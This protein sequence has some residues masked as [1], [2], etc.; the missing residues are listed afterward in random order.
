MTT[1]LISVLQLMTIEKRRQ[2][3]YIFN[4]LT[5][6]ICHSGIVHLVGVSIK[7]EVKIDIVSQRQR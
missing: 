5:E 3:K 2:W 7:S 1:I 6:N 4:M